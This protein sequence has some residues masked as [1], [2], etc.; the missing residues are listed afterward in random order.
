MIRA[1][2]TGVLGMRQ[3]QI[4]MD[5]IGN[6]LANI[7]TVAYKGARAEFQDTLSQTLKAPSTDTANT[8]GTIGMQ[9]GSGMTVS[10]IKNQFTQGSMRN[11]GVRTDLAVN[12]PGFFL[13]KDTITNKLFA[14]H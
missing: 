13:V 4:S 5:V 11:T 7:N 14:S 6:N 8:S 10:S 12:G 1:L 3:F 2:N 9:V